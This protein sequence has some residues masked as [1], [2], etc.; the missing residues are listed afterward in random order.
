[1]F[2]VQRLGRDQSSKWKHRLVDRES[3]V[4]LK[5]SGLYNWVNDNAI[6]LRSKAAHK[7]QQYVSLFMTVNHTVTFDYAICTVYLIYPGIVEDCGQVIKYAINGPG[8]LVGG[9]T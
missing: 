8:W 6:P 2:T 4:C 3:Q 1:M 9:C 7:N 5:E